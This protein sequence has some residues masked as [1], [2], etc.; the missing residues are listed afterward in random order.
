[1]TAAGYRERTCRLGGVGEVAAIWIKRFRRGPMDRLPSAELIE[2]RGIVGN[3]NQRGRR[4][5]TLIDEAAW[6]AATREAGADLDPSTRRA[7]VMLRGVDLARSRGRLLQIG[8]CVVRIYGE[9]RPCEQMEAAHAG[10]LHA[11]DPEWR[12]GAFGEVVR[13]G[14]VE[15]GAAAEWIDAPDDISQKM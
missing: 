15:V 12:G 13:G 3:A 7:N 6:L 2:G 4:Q 9:T 8:E 11:L 10:L 14:T 5:V 1:M